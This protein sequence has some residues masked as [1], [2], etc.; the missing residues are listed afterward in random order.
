MA[1]VTFTVA[2]VLLARPARFGLTEARQM[3]G[4]SAQHVI[5]PLEHLVVWIAVGTVS[6]R[7]GVSTH[8][9]TRPA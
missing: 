6:R 7:C 9:F 2:D 5:Q 3:A 1:A 4:A 8:P